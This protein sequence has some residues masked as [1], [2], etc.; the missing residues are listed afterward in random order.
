[1]VIKRLF[2]QRDTLDPESY[3]L[4]ECRHYSDE[5]YSTASWLVLA[6][7][8]VDTAAQLLGHNV[9]DDWGTE[10]IEVDV[11]MEVKE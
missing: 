2:L 10:M 7:M 11:K 6:T 5:P 8:H 3:R 1:M 9:P 4:Y